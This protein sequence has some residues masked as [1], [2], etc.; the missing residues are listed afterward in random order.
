MDGRTQLRGLLFPR[1]DGPDARAAR[2]LHVATLLVIVLTIVVALGTALVRGA[3]PESFLAHLVSIAISIAAQ[4]LLRRGRVRTA[5]SLFLGILWVTITVFVSLSGGASSPVVATYFPMAVLAAVILGARSGLVLAL[6]SAAILGLF[7]ILESQSMVPPARFEH[8]APLAWLVRSASLVLAGGMALYATRLIDQSLEA[9]RRSEASLAALVRSAPEGIV[10][11]DAEGKIVRL[12]P[13]AERIFGSAE[14]AIGR[15]LLELPWVDASSIERLL[16]PG[17]GEASLRGLVGTLRREDGDERELDLVARPISRSLDDP[18][19]PILRISVRD[20]T[21]HRRAERERDALSEQLHQ[22]QRLESVGLLA[23]GIAHDFNNL[24]TV[25]VANVE[26]L[27]AEITEPAQR[28]GLDEIALAAERATEL[29]RQLLAFSRRQV[30][31][32]R[33]LRLKEAIEHIRHVVRRLIP[34]SLELEL[35]LGGEHDPGQLT[36]VLFNLVVNAR[37]A[38]PA[39]GRLSVRTCDRHLDEPWLGVPAGDYAELVVQDRGGGIEPAVLARIFE[40]FFTTKGPGRGT[41]LGLAVVQGIVAQSNGYVRAESR[42][43]DGSSFHVLF[44]RVS[45]APESQEASEQSIL[46]STSGATVLVA[47]DEPPVRR[48]V[49]RILEGAGFEVLIAADGEQALAT[50]RERRD[51]ELLLTDVVMPRMGG[52]ELAAAACALVPDLEVV[53]MSGYVADA[54][55]GAALPA[56]T[57]LVAKP[58]TAAQLLDAV[59]GALRRAH[60]RI[61]GAE[62]QG[63]SVVA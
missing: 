57:S 24:T 36:Q 10:A 17:L 2:L 7:Y 19:Q 32:P 18:S 38:M 42:L 3:R 6:A 53:F 12:N 11:L 16:R 20:V 23:G 8:V 59:D 62:T 4:A 44:P 5:A 39:G 40:P 13:A 55:E 48:V 25:V 22:A 1:F 15:P 30:L 14:R 46:R 9:L 31:E 63:G 56:T 37:D 51:V 28:E 35:E 45:G 50:L 33:K 47:E 41:G 26:L 49:Q 61:T 43:G 60:E 29:T 52:V 34:E 54:F 21:E 58:F 27:R